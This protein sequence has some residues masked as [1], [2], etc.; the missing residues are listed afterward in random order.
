MK[1][2]HVATFAILLFGTAPA[3]AIEDLVAY[4]PISGEPVTPQFKFSKD[5]TLDY[6]NG[7]K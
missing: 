7:G 6:P 4:L 3:L 5:I 1:M 2:L